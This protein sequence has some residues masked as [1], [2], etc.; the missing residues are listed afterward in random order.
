MIFPTGKAHVSFSEIKNWKEC[1]FRH[2]L[3]YVDKLSVYED[4]PYA[5]FGTI[6]HNSIENYL[7][8]GDLLIQAAQ[9]EIDDV[10]NKKG[11]DT[12][13]YIEKITKERAS[14]GSKYKHEYI[15]FWKSSAKNILSAFP[16]WIDESFPGWEYVSAEEQLYEGIDN[17]ELKFKGYIDCIIKTKKAKKDIYWII[18]W[19]STGPAG[20]W[21]K[22]R[23]DFLTLSQI[24]F[25]KSFWATKNNVPLS[26]VRTAFV[27]LKRGAP[28][29]K[30]IELFKVSAG[31]KFIEKTNKLLE[32]MIFTVNRNFYPK[33]P[34]NCR[35]CQFKNTDFE[36]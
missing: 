24:G 20:W 18:D 26:S 2:K 8:G 34:S 22:K 21:F 29:E 15:D 3:M 11:Y 14:S 9:N 7:K 4:N 27:F 12:L 6:V 16:D 5:D 35:F 10:W 28:K 30:C 19:K 23:R 13:E 32:S 33:N 1:A 31:P 25:Y 17:K 36:K